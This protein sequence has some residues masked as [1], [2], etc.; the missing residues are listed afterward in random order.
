MK[1]INPFSILNKRPKI[2]VSNKTLQAIRHIVSIAPQEAQWF[3]TVTPTVTEK[4]VYLHLSETLYIPK[5]NTSAAQVDSSSAHMIEFYNELKGDHTQ[6]EVN[7]ILST[8]TCWCHSHHN[9]NPSPSGQDNN[10]FN[11]FVNSALEQNQNTWQIM[12]IFNKKD[13]FY[14]RV[15][16]PTTGVVYEGVEII[17]H[18]NYDFSYIDNAAKEKFIIPKPK[19]KLTW[20]SGFSLTSIPEKFNKQ[21]V[22]SWSDFDTNEMIA[23]D[24]LVNVYPE[25]KNLENKAK[26][27]NKKRLNAFLNY[28]QDALDPFELEIFL[29]VLQ[30]DKIS[31][32][33]HLHNSNLYQEMDEE[34]ILQELEEYMKATNKSVR[35]VKDAYLNTL[36]IF[37]LL[38]D[39]KSLNQFLEAI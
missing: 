38:D 13:N 10:Q 11:F 6:E 29:K 30:E 4:D 18:D 14:S 33:S 32:K 1:N 35:F 27:Y 16:D 36:N 7:H 23:N 39:K 15:F 37:D 2:I 5:Q 8:M 9:M 34:I 28:I 21:P 12:L 25:V 20:G 22:S 17:Q 24:L 31:I 19:P 26:L 3:H